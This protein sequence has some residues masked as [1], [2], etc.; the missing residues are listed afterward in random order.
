MFATKAPWRQQMPEFLQFLDGTLG[1]RIT[2]HKEVLGYDLYLIPYFC[3]NRNH[4][5]F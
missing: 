5:Y 2:L 4:F 3:A 1:L